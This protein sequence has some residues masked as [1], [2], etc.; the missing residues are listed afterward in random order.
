MDE[1]AFRECINIPTQDRPVCRAYPAI[2]RPREAV[3]ALAR[4]SRRAG[5]LREPVH[6]G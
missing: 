2:R 5:V 1:D 4:I 3:A 6:H